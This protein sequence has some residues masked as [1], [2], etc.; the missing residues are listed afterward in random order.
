MDS[1]ART[2]VSFARAQICR[3]WMTRGAPSAS[4]LSVI[5][6][7]MMYALNRVH[8]AA[9]TISNAHSS[10]SIPILGFPMRSNKVVK[11]KVDF[12]VKISHQKTRLLTQLRFPP[13]FLRPLQK[14]RRL[15]DHL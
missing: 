5:C 1:P 2:V 11:R 14:S 4:A 15:Q 8:M 3:S 9:G 6:Q 13:K 12:G 7:Q 10:A